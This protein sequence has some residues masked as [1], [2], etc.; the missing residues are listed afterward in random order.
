M[1][2]PDPATATILDEQSDLKPHQLEVFC[3]VAHHLSYVRAA[4]LLHLSQPAVSQ[5][6]KAL[7]TTLGVRLLARSGRG[8]AL[9]PDGEEILP[10]AERLLKTLHAIG[11]VVEEIHA[12]ERGALTVGASTSAGA[13]VV[14]QL[15][16]GFHALRPGIQLTLQ[17]GNRHSIEEDVLAHRVELAIMGLISRHERFTV[18]YLMP[19]DLIMVAAPFHP[20]AA[21]AYIEL[22]TLQGETFLLRE[23]GSGTRQDMEQLFK[24]ADVTL[25]SALELSDTGAIKEAATAGLG[26]AVVFRQ[27]VEREL[28]DGSLI[29]LQV[30]GFPL[31][32]RWYIV[33]LRGG[34]LSLAAS[35]LRGYL[36]T[37]TRA[38]RPGASRPEAQ[39]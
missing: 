8:I 27:S 2:R 18:E 1:A 12:L 28:A 21:H 6:V 29:E 36:L 4:G 32:R 35:A 11:P 20:L 17:V 37:Q 25:R 13:Y 19:N 16:A 24:Q 26:L 14:P 10:S 34:R 30:E 15:L 31:Q 9:T 39:S 3:A 33:H 38:L 22:R 7:E 23:R 5:Q